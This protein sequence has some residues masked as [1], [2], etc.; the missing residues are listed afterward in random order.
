MPLPGVNILKK[1]T[2]EGTVSDIDGNFSIDVVPGIDVLVISYLGYQT[3]TIE[4]KKGILLNRVEPLFPVE[5]N[6]PQVEIVADGGFRCCCLLRC[7]VTRSV[8][9][10]E[11]QDI[12]LSMPKVRIFPIPTPNA[13]FLQQKT[14]LGKLDLYNLSGQK[15]QSFNFSDQLNASI[16]LSALTA[17]TYF[18]RSSNG[19]VEK[20]VLQKQ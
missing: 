15:L 1:N 10:G 6:L 20:V 19:W 13:I 12:D 11:I 2:S 8:G 7:A 18:L 16:D 4:I 9:L 17:G 5:Y 14:P 3:S